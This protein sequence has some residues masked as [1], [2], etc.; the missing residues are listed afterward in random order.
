MYFQ[1]IS[2]TIVN[3]F[4]DLLVGFLPAVAK[5]FV[6]LVVFAVGWAIAVAVAQL[7][8]RL[9]AVLKIDKVLE[10]MGLSVIFER[11]GL[12][13]ES[14][15]FVG[16]LVKWFLILVVFLAV[17]D[18]LGLNAVADY[19]RQI[20]GYIPNLIVAVLILLVSVL[21]GDVVDRAVVASVKA[22]EL[23]SAEFLGKVARWSIYVVALL[24]A[25]I[26]LG[27]AREL[28]L[29]FFTGLVAMVA[30][31]GGL[32]FGFGGQD[33]ARELLG[34]LKKDVEGER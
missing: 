5:V 14:A 1:N 13:L 10:R 19:L 12:K 2:D 33:M 17:V 20:L 3:S 18:V 11:A 34:K 27:I 15:V 29:T 7:I 4:N 9:V 30:L 26:Q 23:R 31:A 8:A 32:A 25:L 22:A 21:L 24:A 6:A 16:W 28:L